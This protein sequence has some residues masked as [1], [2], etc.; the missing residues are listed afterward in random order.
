MHRAT[1]PSQAGGILNP[2]LCPQLAASEG[3]RHGFFTRAG[4]V[5]GGVYHSLNCAYGTGDSPENVNENLRRIADTL[6]AAKGIARLHQVHGTTA[7][8]ATTPWPHDARPQADA[9]VTATPGLAVG[10]STADC[11]PILLADDRHRVVAAAHAGW[12]GALAGIVEATL[13]AMQKLGAQ[14]D[15]IAATIGPA[16]AQGSYEVDAGFRER[17]LLQEESNQIYFIHGA[18]SK[19]FL[20]DLKAYVKDRLKSAGITRI[21]LLAH[22][23]CLQ[24]D[25]FFSYRRTTLRGE[26]AYGCQLSAIMLE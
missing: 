1:Q 10:V 20:F 12:K 23:T 6:G 21:N 11:V 16:I 7:I 9:V 15:T 13:E 14:R 18:R 25:D 26:S 19:H 3:V 8:A 17:F 2:V 5:S 22:D 4:G 24:E